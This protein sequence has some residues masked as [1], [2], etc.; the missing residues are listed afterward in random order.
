METQEQLIQ[1][2][3]AAHEEMRALAEQIGDGKELYPRWTMKHFL[4]HLTGWDEAVTASLQAHSIGNA[5][6]AVADRGI[7]YYNAQSVAERESLDYRHILM[8]WQDSH[9]KYKAAVRAMP[10]D[11]FNQTMIFPWGAVG[12]AADLVAAMTHHERQ[13]FNE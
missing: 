4:A 10:L 11:K 6:G 5:P 9:E 8:E 13:H 2:L 1:S 7:D 3:E 12:S